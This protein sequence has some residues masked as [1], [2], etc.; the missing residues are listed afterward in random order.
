MTTP[1]NYR[2]A[3]SVRSD[4]PEYHD[5]P[6]VYHGQGISKAVFSALRAGSQG[7]GIT[8]HLVATADD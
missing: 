6:E 2:R 5:F 8:Q 1:L 4:F 7:R 3:V